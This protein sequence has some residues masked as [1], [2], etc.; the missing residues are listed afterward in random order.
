[1]TTFN[2]YAEFN[3]AKERCRDCFIGKVYDRVVLGDGNIVK[4]KVVIVG[5]APGKDEVLEGRPFIGK[6]GKL[7]RST[8]NKYGF[9]KTNALITNTIPCRPEDNVFPKDSVIVEKCVQKWLLN[10]LK[11]L[12]PDYIMVVGAT[13]LKY[14]LGMNGI[15]KV[16]GK[17]YNLNNWHREAKC[18]PICHPS[19]VLRKMYMAEGKEIVA[20]FGDDIKLVA[21]TAGFI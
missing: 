19:Y 2:S 5:E 18:M 9:R 15:T 13:P 12:D 17:W 8:L 6:A 1:M 7:L 20:Q 3:L 4:P 21:Q 14:L 11:L 16:R 10:E